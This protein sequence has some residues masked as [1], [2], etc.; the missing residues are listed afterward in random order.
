MKI[1][2]SYT[3]RDNILTSQ[4]FTT[5]LNLLKEHDVFIHFFNPDIDS[6]NK[7]KEKILESDILLLIK[8]KSTFKSK[9][10]IDELIIA[11]KA[12][13]PLFFITIEDIKT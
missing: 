2:I 5:I 6:H 13:I 3:L 4:D 9:W 1:F 8:T 10:V 7:I 12:K 11:N